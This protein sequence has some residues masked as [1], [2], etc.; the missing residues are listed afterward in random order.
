MKVAKLQKEGAGGDQ[1]ELLEA[2]ANYESANLEKERLLQ[3]AQEERA[4]LREELERA[5]QLLFE[6]QQLYE[7]ERKEWSEILAKQVKG[8]GAAV[9]S[10]LDGNRRPAG[11]RLVKNRGSI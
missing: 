6:Q 10:P 5:K 3:S 4:Q 7:R 9:A 2:L 1:S 11:F 8:E